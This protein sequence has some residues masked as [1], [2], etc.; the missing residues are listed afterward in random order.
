MFSATDAQYS[1]VHTAFYCNGVLLMADSR[2]E[3]TD[4]VI[5][6]NP[7]FRPPGFS[8]PSSSFLE[9]S[10]AIEV[11]GKVWSIAEAP[12]PPTSLLWIYANTSTSSSVPPSTF[13]SLFPTTRN[14][15]VNFNFN[16]NFL[17]PHGTAANPNL[18]SYEALS[19]IY[20]ILRNE[21]AIQHFMPPRKFYC[22]TN[23]GVHVL[24]KLRPVDFLR[25]ILLAS[26]DKTSDDL[27]LS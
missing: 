23:T 19:H 12:V 15:N 21:L 7:D 24:I 2:N 17:L 1:D 18:Y 5:A 27:A 10:T 14:L 16:L 25:K 4:T 22:L 8:Q 20:H 26:K 9:R 3:E 13:A 6:T 11:E